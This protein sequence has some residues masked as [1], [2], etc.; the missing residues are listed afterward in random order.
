MIN[1]LKKV[2]KD[3]LWMRK[4][5]RNI[6][7]KGDD[8]FIVSY[9]KSGNTWMRFLIGNILY[10]NFNFSNMEALIPDIYAA[11]NSRIKDL[12]SPRILKSHESYDPRYQKI[13]YIVRD[14]RSVAVSYFFYLKK[15]KGIAEDEKF[16]EF[17]P[18]FINGAF[19]GFGPWDEHVKSWCCT[20]EGK[21]DNFLL[22]K[23]EDLKENAHVELSKIN[24]FLG[25]EF[26]E[27]DIL[28][29]IEQSS[30]SNMKKSELS[31]KHDGSAL[32]KGGESII[33]FVRA[34]KTDEWRE[35][36]GAVELNLLIDAYG[37]T[38]KEIGYE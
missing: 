24:S 2:V 18:K 32:L 38:M 37:D 15:F 34:G 22:I 4:G 28:N 17:L 25:M 36:F 6:D 23:Y 13:I 10:D 1:F 33:P 12:E 29:T 5:G 26:S 3:K 30:F 31:K 35:Y 20:K 11:N 19:G 14:P 21:Q 16:T 8:V 27:I 7:V 9:P